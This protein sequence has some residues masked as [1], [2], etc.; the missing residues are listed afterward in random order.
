MRSVGLSAIALTWT[1]S[2]EAHLSR[3]TLVDPEPLHFDP[4]DRVLTYSSPGG[5]FQIFYVID[6]RNGVGSEHTDG[7]AIVDR[8]ERMADAYD[9]A[10]ATFTSTLGF[11]PPPSDEQAIPENGGDDR[12]DVYVLDTGEVA[13]GRLIEGCPGDIIKACWSFIVHPIAG[14]DDRLFASSFVPTNGLLCHFHSPMRSTPSGRASS[15]TFLNVPL[16][17]IVRDGTR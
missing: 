12:I 9:E 2:A 16:P 13:G 5:R 8:I 10:Y 4:E 11:A 3:P 7:D 15:R 6:G 17:G 14:T 1:V